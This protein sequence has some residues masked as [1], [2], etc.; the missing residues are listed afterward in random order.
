MWCLVRAPDRALT[1]APPA[2]P[3]PGGARKQTGK[4][5]GARPPSALGRPAF[6][7]LCLE[8]VERNG[9]PPLA[10]GRIPPYH[11]ATPRSPAARYAPLAHRCAILW[12]LSGQAQSLRPLAVETVQSAC[13]RG[14]L[15]PACVRAHGSMWMGVSC[16]CASCLRV[17]PIC[18]NLPC[19]CAHVHHTPCT[20]IGRRVTRH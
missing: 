5:C 15:M 7:V 10:A 8:G 18:V 12:P 9:A 1:A 16:A 20:V 13:V 19:A 11:A 17:R 6:S 2:T 4:A 14:P 3:V